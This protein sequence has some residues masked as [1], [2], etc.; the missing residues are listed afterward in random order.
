MDRLARRNASG[1]LRQGSFSCGG[2]ACRQVRQG[3]TKSVFR[4]IKSCAFNPTN[5]VNSVKSCLF[6]FI[7]FCSNFVTNG[8]VSDK[9]F[10]GVIK[11]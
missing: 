1:L 11:S 8:V 10:T 3:K 7:V 5:P 4:F 6:G 9:T 2:R